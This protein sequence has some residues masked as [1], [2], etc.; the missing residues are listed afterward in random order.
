MTSA[1][2][3]TS[4]VGAAWSP[5]FLSLWSAGWAGRK[6]ATAAAISS[7]SQASNSRSQAAASSAAVVTGM[8][9]TPRP[10]ARA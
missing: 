2:G 4:I 1:V 7:T 3:S 5:V 8:T 9:R 10:G 6:S